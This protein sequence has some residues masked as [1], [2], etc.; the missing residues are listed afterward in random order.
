MKL[1]P[2]MLMVGLL[3][4]M[5]NLPILTMAQ[6]TIK[7]VV[8]DAD[9]DEPLIG[10][11]VLI[12]SL[13]K[14]SVTDLDG[15][16]TIEDVPAGEY[17]LICTYTGYSQQTITVT[18]GSG[19]VT[20]DF[21]MGTSATQLDEVVVTGT[22]GPIEKKKIGNTIGTI[23]AKS[24][25]DAPVNSVSDVLG[26]R[27]PGVVALPGSGLVGEGAQIR[28]RGNASLSQLNEPIVIVD[29]IRI[30]R[31]GGFSGFVGAGGG[32][33]ASRLDDINPESIER[34]EILKGASAATLFGTE[35]SNG[36][37][38]I[39][40]KKGQS[41]KP[42]FNVK[43][44]QGIINFPKGKVVDNT[45]FARTTADAS[46]LSSLYGYTIRPWELIYTN[47]LEDLYE[48]GTTTQL[49]ADVSGGTAA[50]NY[51][52]S[53]RHSS[54]D[55]AFGGQENRGY[56]P[57]QSTLADDTDK[58]SQL[59]VN[60]NIFPTDKFSIRVTSGFTDRASTTLSNNNNIYA[61][62]S[63]AQ[64]SKPERR[65]ANNLTGTSAFMTVNEAMQ[66]TFGQ[67][68]KNFNGS[69]G[70]NYY[71]IKWLKLDA[72]Y[73][74]NYSNANDAELWPFRYNID[75]FSGANPL[76]YAAYSNRNFLATTLEVKASLNNKITS[77][78]VSD[79][80]IG[81]QLIQEQT[82]VGSGEGQDF[83]G[84]GLTVTGAAAT[85]N[86]FEF[87]QESINAGL[88]AQE[89]L[90]FND[91]FFLTLGGRLDAHSAFGANFQA[92]FYPK[93]SFSWIP[94]DAGWWSPVGP[95][96]TLQF[97]G[98]WGWAGLQPGA[99]DALTTYA[100]AASA[101]GSAI[102]PQNLGNADLAPEVSKEW[103]VGFTS[104]LFDNKVNFEFT[105]W[106]RVT[107]DA[108]FARQFAPSGGF[109]STQLVNLGT[110][111]AH[112]IEVNINATV[113][114]KKD[115]N[116]ELFANGAYIKE[117][118]ASLGGAPPLKVGGSY[119]RYRNFLIEGY[120][121]GANFGAFLADVPAGS[122]PTDL[123]RDGQPDTRQQAIDFLSELTTANAVLPT[124]VGRGGILLRDDD[125]DGD[126]LDHYLG[127]S[128][129][130]W[131]GSFGTNITWKRFSLKTMFEYRAGNYV[132]NNLTDAF[133]QA[134]AVIGRNMPT[135]ARVERDYIT[136]GVDGN[137]NPQNSGEARLAALEE[138]VYETL[139]LA[140]FSGLN[141][142]EKADF[143]RWRELSVTYTF[144]RSFVDK[145][146]FE[147]MS[148]TG[149]GRNI[150][151]FTGYE[152]VD[153]ELQT[154]GR[155]GAGAIDQ[156]FNQGVAA[157]GWPIPRQ[158]LF[159]LKVGF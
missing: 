37:I 61:V 150:A 67:Q 59:N 144:P 127:K 85:R 64:F 89:Q 22:G 49:A 55:G 9:T 42:R 82:K 69:V 25:V 94:S 68:T 81:G 66:T 90:S 75:N 74:V 2:K 26:G 3:A 141:T 117:N 19:E 140:P 33:T 45:G 99:F 134:N 116:V 16:Y 51:Y 71:P 80:I 47:A 21:S 56:L 157:F 58:L 106:D 34:I 154:F 97:R 28:I 73:G 39:F 52:V 149:A 159:T 60:L 35:A 102:V 142:F 158:I 65:T 108:L 145:L 112:G 114:R 120:A 155:G 43:L 29:G 100:P 14:G 7:G 96:S 113:I 15:S 129:P 17:K 13:T 6:G 152:G 76:G 135:S 46:R 93:V 137:F 40:T 132:V 32:G 124:V 10:A 119:P 147:N 83:P 20:A 41:G 12:E 63:L 27:T 107:E 104:G 62:G 78:I 139:A 105:Y 1:R 128:V 31:G 77:T 146:G 72:T 91:Q 136:G 111:E 130:D 50:F 126:L 4:F 70:I 118:V 44:S 121:P 88:F 125:G 54:T 30:D 24:L 109:R 38:Q 98:S 123:N 57:G 148:L 103:E 95:I 23:S 87:F 115:F 122:L 138:W 53:A 133:R 156:N 79:L 101:S 5:F 153:P 8:I 36:V 131:T 143:I 11:T 48:T 86:T 18:V 92:Q 110:L 84:P 151:I